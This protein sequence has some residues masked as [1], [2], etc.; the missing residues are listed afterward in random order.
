M[1][2]RRLTLAGIVAFVVSVLAFAPASLV[3]P[4]LERVPGLVPTGLDGT[5]WRGRAHLL[6]RG[7]DLGDVRFAFS[8][9]DLL[10]LRLGYRVELNGSATDI[11]ARVSAGWSGWTLV[12]D[13]TIDLALL[14]AELARYDLVIPGVLTLAGLELDAR[15]GATLP[16]ARGEA[17]WDG[18]TVRYTLGGRTS[19]SALPPLTGFVDSTAGH[20]QMTVY[21]TDDATPLLLARVTAD[22]M[23]SVGI[24]KQFT[25]RVGQPWPGGDEDHAVVLEVSEDL[26]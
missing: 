13:G 17:R 10:R 8:P 6:L 22:G 9:A 2:P 25:K 12:A 15:Y 3:R 23:A 21:A 4:L 20:P 11:A 7:T 18:G 5:I 1:T 24:T 14:R 16:N 26:F 19:E